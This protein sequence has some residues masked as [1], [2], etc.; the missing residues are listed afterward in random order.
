MAGNEF[1]DDLAKE[2]AAGL[3]H[4]VRDEIRWLTSLPHLFRRIIERRASESAQW[5][6]SHVRPE[7]RHRP[8][9]GTKL[10]CKA[11]RKVRESLAGRYYQ[12]L[13]GHA[14]IGSFLHE[15]MTGPLRREP[16]KCRRC[17]S[18]KREL[19]HHLFTE[20]RAWG[21]QTQRP[22]KRVGKDCGRK[23]QGYRW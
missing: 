2:A 21:P 1:V 10:H 3:A 15:R 9:S 5:V 4:G 22:Q 19:L 14:A 16:G 17:D 20:R 6:T 18:G 12:L 8:P 23:H 13:A 11:L 7:R